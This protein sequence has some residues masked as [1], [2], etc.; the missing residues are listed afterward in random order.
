M[1]KILLTAILV[2]SAVTVQADDKFKLGVEGGFAIAD[3]GAE[4]VAQALANSTGRTVTYTEEQ[5]TPYFRI[6]GAYELNDQFDLEVGYFKAASLDSDYTLA[7][8]SGSVGV[9]VEVSGWD[10]GGRFNVNDNVFLK[11][12]MHSSEM[13]GT[14]SVT[15][16]GTTYSASASQDGTGAYFGGGY[17][18]NDN[19]SVGFTHL[20][21]LAGDSDADANLLYV[22]YQF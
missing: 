4:D 16:S 14:V 1:R 9:G 20:S 10:L 13:E 8:V 7:G 19:L 5:G 2:T 21:S 3:L 12:G 15:I 6:Y 11:A 18:F 22:G 17:N